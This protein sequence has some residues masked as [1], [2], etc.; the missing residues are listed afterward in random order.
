MIYLKTATNRCRAARCS[1]LAFL[2]LMGLPLSAAEPEP[3]D[4]EG[5]S[6]SEEALESSV[7]PEAAPSAESGGEPSAKPDREPSAESEGELSA[8]SEG[9]PPVES[10]AESTVAPES[11]PPAGPAEKP[12]AESESEPTVETP[13]ESEPKPEPGSVAALGE[14]L[15][16]TARP[17][18][19]AP[20]TWEVAVRY[21]L[22][23][24]GPTRFINDVR[25]GLM[26]GLELRTALMPFP[27]SIMLRGQLQRLA[28]PLGTLWFYGGLE[29]W[30]VGFRLDEDPEESQVGWRWHLQG[31]LGWGKTFAQK[32]GVLAAVHFR[33]RL[34]DLEEDNQRA[35]AG[36]VEL[37]Y[38]LQPRIGLIWAAGYA[39]TLD[40][41]VR[42]VYIGFTQPGQSYWL[43]QLDRQNPESATTA[44]A[45]TYGRT[46]SFDVDV[47]F[48][49]RVWPEDGFVFG[50]GLRWR[51]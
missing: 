18:V 32:I 6:Q 36:D 47:F 31:T 51:F 35:F 46:E 29:H 15:P 11:E 3:G 21:G 13:V 40:T 8:A 39:Q 7:D 38:D 33:E 19:L 45:M 14:A 27:S 49:Y 50:S 1:T 42:E 44:L 30:D 23:G 22:V 20:K 48:S 5:T 4:A 28:S 34:T 26:P 12:S 9:E 2:L 41:P 17:L 25:V 24:N 43:H 10:A 37:R 16:I